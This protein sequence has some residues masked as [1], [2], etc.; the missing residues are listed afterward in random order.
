MDKLNIVGVIAEKHDVVKRDVGFLTKK[1]ESG[2]FAGIVGL[3]GEPKASI[4]VVGVSHASDIKGR[5]LRL[6]EGLG[7]GECLIGLKK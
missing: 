6:E 1:L 2:K 4:D 7:G 5:K 3:D